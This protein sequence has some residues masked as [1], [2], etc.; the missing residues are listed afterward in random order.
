MD[1]VV[2]VLGAVVSG[3]LAHKVDSLYVVAVGVENGR[4]DSFGKVGWVGGGTGKV[5]IG[6][7]TDLVVDDEMDGASRSVDG[8][9]VEAHGFVYDTLSSKSGITVEQNAH[10]GVVRLFVSFEILNGISFSEHDGI[11]ASR[12]E[13]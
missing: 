12:W 8:E 13:G 5:G 1:D 3:K 4:V 6:S 11:L 9:V 2:L 7:E 10:S